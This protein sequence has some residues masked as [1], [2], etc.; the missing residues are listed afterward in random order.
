MKFGYVLTVIAICFFSVDCTGS[1]PG[2]DVL[3][4]RQTLTRILELYDAGHDNLFNE[5]YPYQEENKVTYLAG[6]DKAEGKRVAY[7]WPTSGLFSGL[8][9]LYRNSG[10]KEYYHLLRKKLIPGLENYFDSKREP[11][12]Y[13][14]YITRAGKSDRFYDDNIWL[15]ID[16]CE[17]YQLT[18]EEQFLE[19]SVQLWEFIQ[20]GRDEKLGGG[21]YWCEQ[22]KASKNTCS[23]APAAVLALKL[24]EATADRNY[25]QKGLQI[26][27]WTKNHLQDPSDHLYFDNIKLSGEIDSV[28]YT[29][30]SGQMLQAASLLYKITGEQKYLN[31]A[32]KIA[33]SAI[34]YFT[35]EFTISEGKKIHLFKNT[36]NWFNT[37]LFRGYEEL[38]YLDKN[39]EYIHIFRENLAYLW[40]YVRDKNGLFGKDWAGEK[41]EKHK[42]LLDQASLVELWARM[43]NFEENK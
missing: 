25:F 3:K 20:S 36:G 32:Q 30:N 4:A 7:L 38:F 22:K 34:Q 28:K 23:N 12:C 11:F 1:K 37:V 6:E 5:T 19:K 10:D 17:L 15:G 26:Y 8:I 43:S 33:A 16:F 24:F 27:E 35:S 31:E 21:I 42:W 41:Q 2:A 13:Q 39:P 40:E 18:G 9:S 14:S 29:Y